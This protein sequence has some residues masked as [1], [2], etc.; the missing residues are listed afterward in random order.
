MC[1]GTPEF[2]WISLRLFGI[3]KN[4]N[5]V[6]NC[7][8]FLGI[9]RQ[10]CIH[11]EAAIL[12]MKRSCPGSMSG[13]SFWGSSFLFTFFWGS[14]A[15][16]LHHRTS[17]SDVTVGRGWSRASPGVP[18]PAQHPWGS[19]RYTSLAPPHIC[20]IRN[21]GQDPVLSAVSSPSGADAHARI[22]VQ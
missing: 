11:M 3:L 12:R 20:G 1:P 5:S 13:S 8:L 17:P 7:S 14:S 18:H 2:A 6:P 16:G 10:S 21:S 22:A 15:V 4:V 9:L 19:A